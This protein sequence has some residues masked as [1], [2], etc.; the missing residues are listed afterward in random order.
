VDEWSYVAFSDG[1]F[2]VRGL[3]SGERVRLRA[4]LRTTRVEDAATGETTATAGDTA[5]ALEVREGRPFVLRVEGETAPAVAVLTVP[6]LLYP[7]FAALIDGRARFDGVDPAS[8]VGASVIGL[9]D[10]KVAHGVSLPTAS[11][12][13]T[14]RV[15]PGRT[16]RGRVVGQPAAA[17]VE[18]VTLK[19]PGWLWTGPV[20]L[21]GTFEVTGAP[22]VPVRASTFATV[23]GRW[24]QGTAKETLG[25]PVELR[26]EE[27]ERLAPGHFRTD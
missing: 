18:H 27:V 7:E 6:G 19:A 9:P 26:M 2:R 22:A 14:I 20:R 5:V 21:D 24:W 11:G 1:T 15:G 17:G 4:G 3:R 25:A 13:A 12:E 23:G 10:D 8:R 16:V